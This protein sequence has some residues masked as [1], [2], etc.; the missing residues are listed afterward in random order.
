LELKTDYVNALLKEIELQKDYLE[1]EKV[2]TI[3]FGGGT[4]S[5]L[6]SNEINKIINE[7]KK[8]F[9]IEIN[10]E[11]TLE[12]NPESLSKEKIKEISET[13]VNRLSIGV[14]SLFDEDLKYLGRIHTAK[15]SLEAI[16][17]VQ[18]YGFKN[19][20]IDLIYGIPSLTNEKWISNLEQIFLLEV[21]HI[22]AYSLT[23]ESNTPLYNLIEEGKLNGIDE[24]KIAEQFEILMKLMYEN[25]YI[26]YEISNF[27]K[28]GF[29][30]LHNSNYWKQQKY[31]GIG[32]SAHSYSGI[33]RQWN[34]ANNTEYINS[35]INGII[36]FEKEIL[37]GNQKYNEYILTTLRTIWGI[38]SDYIKN[39]F[40]EF[41]LEYFFKQSD[42]FVRSEKM[43]NKN[44][45]FLL[46][47]NGKIIADTIIR[48]LFLSCDIC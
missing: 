38:D 30:S 22:S 31:L 4:P 48:S 46:S 19:L 5:L 29:Y 32:A 44:N 8:Y 15:Q 23:V 10:S 16:K 39:N 43:I 11:I 18:K 28:E 13:S 1:N 35:I 42:K 14:Q 34:V 25:N 40:G 3:Y 12:V 41:Y 20:S 21:P 7:I 27:C 9:E 2:E 17:N 24:D 47:N 26:H 37:A 45:I 33:S 36:P 6:S